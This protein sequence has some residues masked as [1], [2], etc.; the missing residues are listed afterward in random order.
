MN[1]VLSYLLDEAPIKP[2]TK[3]PIPPTKIS[4]QG[5]QPALPKKSDSDDDEDEDKDTIKVPGAY[6]PADYNHLNI[7]PEIEDLFRYI[8]R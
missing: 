8:T 7:T 3:Q 1:N 4:A 5:K 6:N 2:Q